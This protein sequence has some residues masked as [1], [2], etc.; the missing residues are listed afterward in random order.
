MII[1]KVDAIYNSD[2]K[3]DYLQKHKKCSM[4]KT[5]ILLGYDYIQVLPK[6]IEDENIF[7]LIL[8]NDKKYFSKN[9]LN[10]LEKRMGERL[11]HSNIKPGEVENIIYQTKASVLLTLG[12][13]KLIDVNQF[14][15]M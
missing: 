6:N 7:G 15:N 14:R 10:S 13:R 5:I 12:W 4:K 2:N 3:Q 11:I 8:E 1:Y 9:N